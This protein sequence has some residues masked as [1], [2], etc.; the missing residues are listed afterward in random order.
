MTER[1]ELRCRGG[2]HCCVRNDVRLCREG[3][4]DCARDSDCDV[5]LICGQNNCGG[6]GGLWDSEG[7]IYS[8]I[9]D[10]L[11]TINA[12]FVVIIFII[13]IIMTP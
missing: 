10:I 4:G 12:I 6:Q 1:L 13:F 8:I 2:D 5:G 7:V 11:I 9:M 3:E